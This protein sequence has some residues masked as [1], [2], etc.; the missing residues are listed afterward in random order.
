M[1]KA[2]A[3]LSEEVLVVIKTFGVENKR[4]LYELHC[5]MAF[6]GRGAIW[7]QNNDQVRN[8]YFG[9]TMLK[10]ADRVNL[11]SFDKKKQGSHADHKGHSHKQP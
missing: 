4:P 2:F 11:I 5:P 7:L 6:K 8:P 1:R 3:L 10:C 9:A